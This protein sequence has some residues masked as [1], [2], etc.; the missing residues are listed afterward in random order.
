M[1]PTGGGQPMS[2]MPMGG[3]S[4][5]G[6]PTGASS[7]PGGPGPDTPAEQQA[8]KL[9]T[10]ADALLSQAAQIEPSISHILTKGREDV[11]LGV[12]TAW[13]MGQQAKLSLQQA[14]L[15]RDQQ[16]AG[17]VGLT[18]PPALPPMGGQPTGPTGTGGPMA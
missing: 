5:G 1:G 7:G 8:L 4:P 11:F 13:G 12:M 18:G 6:P 17:K 14:K 9:L 3:P 2:E 16:Q 15:Q 10:Q